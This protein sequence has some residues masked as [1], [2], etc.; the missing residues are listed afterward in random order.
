MSNLKYGTNEPI[1]KIETDSQA[2]KTDLWLPGRQGGE[3]DGRGVWGQ[4]MQTITF[5]MDK[6]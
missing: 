4:Q 3:R 2:W 5:R 1:H 6:Q